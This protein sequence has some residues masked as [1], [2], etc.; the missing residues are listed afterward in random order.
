V[1]TRIDDSIKLDFAA[2]GKVVYIYKSC[3]VI[4]GK[5]NKKYKI[6]YIGKINDVFP[7]VAS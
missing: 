3:V 1:Q 6:S 4:S 7:S 2:A 5:E